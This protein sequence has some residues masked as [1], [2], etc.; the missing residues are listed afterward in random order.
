[1]N[2]DT[3]PAHVRRE[4]RLA[5]AKAARANRGPRPARTVKVADVQPGDYVVKVPP[6]QGIRGLRIGEQVLTVSDPDF[7]V[8]R[9]K[10]RG[11]MPVDARWIKTRSGSCAY[12]A[13]ATVV[14]R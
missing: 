7:E 4:Q 5:A 13:D 1:M 10:G 3:T 11:Q 8:Y 6:Y 9:R 14:V 2:N 12:P